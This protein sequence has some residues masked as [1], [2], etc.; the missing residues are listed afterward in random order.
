M[1]IFK[2]IV[3]TAA[4]GYLDI[5]G[6]VRGKSYVE[7]GTLALKPKE[8]IFK[9]KAGKVLNVAGEATLTALAGT[10]A[11]S[12]A[13]YKAASV[14]KK[15]TTIAKAA[16]SAAAIS[17]GTGAVTT[18][19]QTSPKVAGVAKKTFDIE[20]TAETLGTAIEDPSGKNILDAIRANPVLYLTL[21][22]LLVGKS[23]LTAASIYNNY[24]LR[25][26]LGGGN[27]STGN[28]G[29]IPADPNVQQYPVT[30]QT[31]EMPS[32]IGQKTRYKSRRRQ[33]KE[34]P[35]KVLQRVNVI[36]SNIANKKY[37][38]KYAYEKIWV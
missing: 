24:L 38:N 1:G 16:G 32:T 12:G 8:D 34:I 27:G 30:P 23:A 35:M 22:G 36:V 6:K 4:A 31:Q 21:G 28:Q 3:Q 20:K 7:K 29:V 14:A 2:Q 11:A 15:V 33:K 26:N 9:T 5:I 19:L 25:K 37:I 13:A 10:A 18:L 17:A